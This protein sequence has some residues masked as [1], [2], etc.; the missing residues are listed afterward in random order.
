[1]DYNRI[2][3]WQSSLTLKHTDY[4][5]HN[6][7]S[8]LREIFLFIYLFFMASLVTQLIKNTHA[9]WGTWVQSP[10]WEY[11]MEK[12][13]ATHSSILAWIIPWTV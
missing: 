8:I 7:L 10:G 5:L 9:M 1:M 6:V 12:G 11:P 4:K 3:P 13:K 2:I